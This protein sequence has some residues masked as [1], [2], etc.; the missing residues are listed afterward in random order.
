MRSL[1]RLTTAP[2][3]TSHH[4]EQNP[5][6]QIKRNGTISILIVTI[7][8]ILANIAYFAAGSLCSAWC[9]LEDLHGHLNP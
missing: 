4:R 6:K 7:L 3:T 2:L 1:V 5:I 8:Y 9:H